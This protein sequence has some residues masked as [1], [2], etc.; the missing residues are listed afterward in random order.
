MT[1]DALTSDIPV[2]HELANNVFITS[3]NKIYNWSRRN[4][5]WP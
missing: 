2:P 3:I 5:V 4:S 1:T